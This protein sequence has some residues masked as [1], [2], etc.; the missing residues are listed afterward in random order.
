MSTLILP[1]QQYLINRLY[2]EELDAWKP[3][4]VCLKIPI[5][6]IRSL[7]QQNGSSEVDAFVS[8]VVSGAILRTRF[9][10]ALRQKGLDEIT[11]DLQSGAMEI[12]P[13][14][15][16]PVCTFGLPAQQDLID[17]FNDNDQYAWRG[18]ARFS[19]I[20]PNRICGWA[21]QSRKSHVEELIS[22]VVNQSIPRSRFC[23]ALQN[24]QLIEIARNLETE[25]L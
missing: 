5:N 15:T 17:S 13:D 1:A 3:V 25:S 12:M 6:R 22:S 9:C 8:T 19:G 11:N 24:Q 4:A 18:V 10:S 2:D 14:F 20:I 21:Q 23:W 16:G 7:A